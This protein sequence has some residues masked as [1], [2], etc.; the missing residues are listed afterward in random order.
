MSEEQIEFTFDQ[1]SDTAKAKV[2]DARRYDDVEDQWW[3]AVYEDAVVV[4][5]KIGI[6]IGTRYIPIVGGK[7]VSEI[8]I[9]FSGFA[10][11]GDGCCYSGQLHIASLK[12]CSTAIKEHVGEDEELFAL[13]LRGEALY[14]TL[15]TRLMALR[16]AGEWDGTTWNLPDGEFALNG[17]IKIHGAERSYSTGVD[18][19]ICDE[20]LEEQLDSYV[21]DFADW[22]YSQ[23]EAEHDYLTSDDHLDQWLS[24]SEIK[25]D[26]D[27]E[28][29]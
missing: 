23:L 24:D 13:A 8:N 3:D 7:Y 26:E 2:R 6:E 18:P 12:D 17:A 21:S 10:S 27:G 5:A 22:I 25:F 19:D 20:D 28:E 16:M 4:G 1:L 15:A 29:T 11:Q 9:S 14:A